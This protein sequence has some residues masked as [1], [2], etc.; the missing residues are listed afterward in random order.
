MIKFETKDL[1]QTKFLLG[2]QFEH[3]PH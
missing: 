2:S 3:L 1:G